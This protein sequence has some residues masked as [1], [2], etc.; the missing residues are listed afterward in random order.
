MT[1]QKGEVVVDGG[2][3]FILTRDG[4]GVLTVHFHPPAKWSSLRFEYIT[5][6]VDR[7]ESESESLTLHQHVGSPFQIPSAAVDGL[8]LEA[9]EITVGAIGHNSDGK[10]VTFI[11]KTLDRHD[12]P[13]DQPTA[14]VATA[15]AATNGELATPTESPP[16][17]RDPGVSTQTG[18]LSRAATARLKRRSA[19]MNS[20]SHRPAKRPNNNLA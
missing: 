8:S 18:S 10:P 13:K 4:A 20:G 2:D 3:F 11:S 6:E 5:T 14:A 16:L 12:W 19:R 1:E 17:T 7:S 9:M 15:N